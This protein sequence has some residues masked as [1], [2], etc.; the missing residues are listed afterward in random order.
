MLDIELNTVDAFQGR[1]KDLIIISTVRSN[2]QGSIG[3]VSD[4]KAHERGSNQGK[5][6]AL[7]GR[8]R[9]HA[10][11]QLSLGQVHSARGATTS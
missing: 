8:Q 2:D 1:E 11:K 9:L 3:F 10:P 7:R 6:R 5:V 4:K